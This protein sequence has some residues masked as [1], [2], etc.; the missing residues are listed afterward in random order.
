MNPIDKT[1]LG[2]CSDSG[3]LRLASLIENAFKTS[4]YKEE[5]RHNFCF[6]VTGEKL[7]EVVS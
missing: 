4:S 3:D 2:K 6:D 5:E 1:D 7:H